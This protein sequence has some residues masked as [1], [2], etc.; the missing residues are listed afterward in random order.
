MK[1]NRLPEFLII[2]A[3]KSGTTAIAKYLL[4]HNQIF[5]PERKE[6]RFFSGMNADF[7]GPR[8]NQINQTIIKDLNQYISL[9]KK[10]NNTQIKGDAS[11]DYLFYYNSTIKNIKKH[12]HDEKQE[13]PKIIVILRNPILRAFSNY[14]H[15]LRDNRE[16]E[17]FLTGISLEEERKNKNW[18]WFWRYKEQGFYTKQ[19]KPFIDEFPNT[20]VLIYDDFQKDNQK[21]L[22]EITDYLGLD[23]KQF[24]FSKKHN[25]S[26]R[27]KNKIFH[28]ISSKFVIPLSLR[29]VLPEK[30]LNQLKQLKQGIVSKNLEKVKISK[31]E[32]EYLKEL[33]TED[34]TQLGELLNRDLSHWLK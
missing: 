16:Y 23:K 31:D 12:Y 26:G 10:A 20:K 4:E 19:V 25:E 33:Y 8:D 5:I 11:P 7:K 32:K 14:M 15:L 24:D 6:C 18:E 29:K 9:F 34:I 1:N 2:G 28:K 27:P 17:S 30:S 3:A 13:Y 22:N 21:V